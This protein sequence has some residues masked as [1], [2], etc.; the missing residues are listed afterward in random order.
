M[1]K[2]CIFIWHMTMVHQ[3]VPPTSKLCREQKGRLLFQ[4]LNVVTT[5]KCEPSPQIW[6]D[7]SGSSEINGFLTTINSFFSYGHWKHSK[8]LLY[9][10][11]KCKH[12]RLVHWGFSQSSA[13]STSVVAQFIW[14]H[15]SLYG[16]TPG[17]H[18]CHLWNFGLLIQLP[19]VLL[20]SHTGSIW[21][22]SEL[23]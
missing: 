19:A 10:T 14:T 13:N 3:F 1:I 20:A 23:P 5:C 16:N 12:R 9:F 22:P 6:P 11:K 7:C 21:T 2:I 18:L 15:F 17:Q 4:H 8:H